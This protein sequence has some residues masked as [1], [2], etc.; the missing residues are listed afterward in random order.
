MQGPQPINIGGTGRK[1]VPRK[2]SAGKPGENVRTDSEVRTDGRH[3]TGKLGEDIA[4]E[5]LL[6]MGYKLLERNWHC[7]HKEVDLIMEGEDGLHIVEVRTR[8]EPT[9]VEP[10]MTVDRHKQRNLEAAAAAWLRMKGEYSQVHF[11][12]VSIVLDCN[13]KVIRHDLIR[14][15]FIPLQP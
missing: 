1:Q 15:A 7:R 12:I 3:K 8:H 9:A 11:D 4:L 13:S 5:H 6:Q 10:E 2:S 14:D